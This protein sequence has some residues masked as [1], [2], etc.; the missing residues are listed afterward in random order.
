[1]ESCYI[2][3]DYNFP[4]NIQLHL[5]VFLAKLS[6]FYAILAVC[7][8]FLDYNNPKERLLLNSLSPSTI[9]H[10]KRSQVEKEHFKTNL[11]VLLLI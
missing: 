6:L 10:T 7:P 2:I 4:L 3:T 1:M 9:F 8:V 11:H 5:F